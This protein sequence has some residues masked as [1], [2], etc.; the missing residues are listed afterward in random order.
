MLVSQ[1]DVSN[2]YSHTFSL[3]FVATSLIDS[4][5]IKCYTCYEESCPK[6]WN[7]NNIEQVSSPSGWCL[8]FSKD[9]QTSESIYARN[10]ALSGT[11]TESKCEWRTNST[12]NSFYFCCCNTDLCNGSDREITTT[13]TN[14]QIQFISNIYFVF[15]GF[16]TAFI[17]TKS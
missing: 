16:F 12:G 2:L 14:G 3:I 4:F 13:P 15:I 5:N 10:W 1:S 8:T 11:C 9:N 17:M 7:P 6:P